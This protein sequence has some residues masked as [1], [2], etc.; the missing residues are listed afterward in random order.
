LIGSP[1]SLFLSPLLVRTAASATGSGRRNLQTMLRVGGGGGVDC[2][3]TSPH[4]PPASC[5]SSSNIII[6]GGGGVSLAQYTPTDYSSGNGR[7]AADSMLVLS[8]PATASWSTERDNA[9]APIELPADVSPMVMQGLERD[10][11]VPATAT[12][13][14]G[15]NACTVGNCSPQSM[16]VL[17]TV[18]LQTPQRQPQVAGLKRMRGFSDAAFG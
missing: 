4:T 15:T 5:S 6:C 14:T 16:A 3:L 2:G 18:S 10:V 7:V 17:A 9:D 11:P 1:Q 13:A 12:A 8:P